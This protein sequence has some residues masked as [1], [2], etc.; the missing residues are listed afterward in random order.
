MSGHN[1]WAQIKHQKGTADAKKSREFSK[2]ARM[3]SV[4][5][6]KGEDP[7]A[8][9]ELRA[10][11]EKAKSINMPSDNIERAVR[12]GGGKEEG[13]Q[14]ENIR[15]EAYGPG[16]VAMIIE[17]ITDNKNRSLAEIKHL[18]S[19]LGAKFGEQGSVL[20]AFENRNGKWESKIPVQLNEEDRASLQR[21]I[22]AL[23]EH[24]DV[25]E[26]FTNAI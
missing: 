20:W 17:G 10:V 19:G 1:K 18:L 5:A 22:E 7:N 15:Y 3:I 25:Q 4:A 23:D 21:L 11:I 26:I 6:R 13:T 9:P 16:G 2:L 12:R 14:L 8:N 24:D